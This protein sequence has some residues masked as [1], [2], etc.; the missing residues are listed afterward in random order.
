MSLY[1]VVEADTLYKT[2]AGGTATK[3]KL[4]SVDNGKS[5]TVFLNGKTKEKFDDIISDLQP[6]DTV[7]ANLVPNGSFTNLVSIKKS[8]GVTSVAHTETK[9]TSAIPTTTKKSSTAP[10]GSY[11]DGQIG[12]Q[13]GHALTLAATLLTNP[14]VSIEDVESLAEKIILAGNS[15]RAKIADGSINDTPVVTKTV[16]KSK[17]STPTSDGGSYEEEDLD[18]EDFT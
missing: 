18:Y 9:V 10:S 5:V 4:E 13:V 11:A 6:Q 17:V 2:R 3:I 15:L 8:K 7:E 14:K 16:K 12:M 1:T